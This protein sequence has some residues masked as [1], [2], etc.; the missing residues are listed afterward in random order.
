MFSSSLALGLSVSVTPADRRDRPPL[1]VSKQYPLHLTTACT[2]YVIRGAEG[3]GVGWG[4][5]RAYID[6]FVKLRFERVSE[7]VICISQFG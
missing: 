5:E 4:W 1:P 6:M 7:R 2:V 3:V